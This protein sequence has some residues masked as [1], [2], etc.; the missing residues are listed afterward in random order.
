MKKF[1]AINIVFMFIAAS[2][3]LATNISATTISSQSMDVTVGEVDR[4]NDEK[5]NIFTP[6]TGISESNANKE[7]VMLTTFFTISAVAILVLLL[8]HT[9]YK[10]TKKQQ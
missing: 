3:T 1:L 8:S 5:Q 4:I 9:H 10:H 7:S 2:F 6:N